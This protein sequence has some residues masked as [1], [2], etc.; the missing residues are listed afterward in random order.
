MGGRGGEVHCS[1]MTIT[2]IVHAPVYIVNCQEEVNLRND[3]RE[4]HG[5]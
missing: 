2:N 5:T 3:I 1:K 4:K